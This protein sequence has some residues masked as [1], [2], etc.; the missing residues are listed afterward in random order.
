LR[1]PQFPRSVEHCLTRISNALLELPRYEAAMDGC[2]NV[3]KMLVDTERCDLDA[4]TLHECMDQL[5]IGI[6]QLHTAIM[7][8]YFVLPS[9]VSHKKVHKSGSLLATA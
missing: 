1:D 6:D 3:Q 7:E 2:A 4:G 9:H 5:Q 8:T